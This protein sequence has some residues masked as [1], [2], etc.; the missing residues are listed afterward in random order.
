[1]SPQVALAVV[2]VKPKP[3]TTCLAFYNEPNCP[4]CPDRARLALVTTVQPGKGVR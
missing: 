2:P 4:C 1:V 3:G